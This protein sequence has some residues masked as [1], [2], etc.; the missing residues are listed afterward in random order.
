M[1]SVIKAFSGESCP[2]LIRDGPPSPSNATKVSASRLYAKGLAG[3]HFKPKSTR[4]EA[5]KFPT[6]WP[7]IGACNR[8]AA[9]RQ[10]QLARAA[11]QAASLRQHDTMTRALRPPMRRSHQNHTCDAMPDRVPGENTHMGLMRNIDGFSLRKQ[12]PRP[13]RNQLSSRDKPRAAPGVRPIASHSSRVPTASR[14][15]QNGMMK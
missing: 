14:A 10:P 15:R 13:S 8:C 5:T 2:D 12:R 6:L 1:R 7:T 4:C 9:N 11:R 3:R